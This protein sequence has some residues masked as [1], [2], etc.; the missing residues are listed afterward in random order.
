MLFSP[1][2]FRFKFATAFGCRYYKSDR[3]LYTDRYFSVYSSLRRV[4]FIGIIRLPGFIAGYQFGDKTYEYGG[5]DA[6]NG[7][8][9]AVKRIGPW[10]G[11]M[12]EAQRC[13]RRSR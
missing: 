8:Q 1:D 4:A 11:V 9:Q 13:H 3:H 6:Q 10:V 2:P 7:F 5:G 12:V